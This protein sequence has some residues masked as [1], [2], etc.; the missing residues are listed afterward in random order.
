MA[1]AD[2]TKEAV[3]AAILEYD[4][5]GGDAFPAQYGS[6][7]AKRYCLELNGKRYPSKTIAGATV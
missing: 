3:D 4:Q 5:L 2:I 7:P 1:L 6:A